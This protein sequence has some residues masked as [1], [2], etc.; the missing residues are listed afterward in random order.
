MDGFPTYGDQQAMMTMNRAAYGDQPAAMMAN[1]GSF[2]GSAASGLSNMASDVGS[3][4]RPIGYTPPARI[5]PSYGGMYAQETGFF[6]GLAG[7]VGFDRSVPR[8][9]SAY[10]Y[11]TQQAAD[12]GERVGMGAA[13]TTTALGGIAAGAA[14]SGVGT[15]A[16]QFVGGAVGAAVGS[17]LGPL[18]TMSG[19]AVGRVAGGF[20]G[21]LASYGVGMTGAGMVNEAIGQRR[22]IQSFLSESSFRFA[23][24]GSALSAGPDWSGYVP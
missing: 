15:V 16:G 17:V 12:I 6:S 14:L 9:T 4:V 23:S 19:A 18:G 10:A 24:A 20:I 21:G 11:H 2:Y 13:S 22:E 5:Y 8:G 7:Q 1:V 3:L